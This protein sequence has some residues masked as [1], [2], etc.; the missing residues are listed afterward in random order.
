[1][2][3]HW[4]DVP[5]TALVL[6]MLSAAGYSPGKARQPGDVVALLSFFTLL[7]P[8]LVM[9][10]A[11]AVAWQFPF[12][13]EMHAALFG[14]AASDGAGALQGVASSAGG[15]GMDAVGTDVMPF[16]ESAGFA[17][18]CDAEAGTYGTRQ[19]KTRGAGKPSRTKGS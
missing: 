6:A 13:R 4:I 17:Q 1:M 10:C 8:G 14:A 9:L 16:A 18:L 11:M 12:T 5:A 19:R 3:L 7:L 15:E 2:A